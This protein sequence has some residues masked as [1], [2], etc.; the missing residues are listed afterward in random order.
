MSDTINTHWEEHL[1][2]H[3]P[4]AKSWE[5]SNEVKTLSQLYEIIRE[6]DENVTVAMLHGYLRDNGYKGERVNSVVMWLLC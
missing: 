4:P 1:Q 2:E 3:F 5:E 6:V